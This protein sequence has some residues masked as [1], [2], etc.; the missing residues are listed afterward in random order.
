MQS[1]SASPTR[2][3]QQHVVD[4]PDEQVDACVNGTNVESDSIE[5]PMSQSS[6]QLENGHAVFPSHHSE[7][8]AASDL[9]PSQDALLAAASLHTDQLNEDQRLLDVPESS[10][11]HADHCAPEADP[12]DVSTSKCSD[13]QQSE[14]DERDLEGTSEQA[15]ARTNRCGSD[16]LDND[17]QATTAEGDHDLTATADSALSHTDEVDEDSACRGAKQASAFSLV[18]DYA[19]SPSSQG[20]D[21]APEEEGV[22]QTAAQSDTL[23]VQH[24]EIEQLAT[25]D[26]TSRPCASAAAAHADCSSNELQE[27]QIGTIDADSLSPQPIETP[28]APE[29]NT[30]ELADRPV[31]TDEVIKS[32]TSDTQE[33]PEARPAEAAHPSTSDASD[34]ELFDKEATDRE[35]PMFTE[36]T[37]YVDDSSE[38]DQQDLGQLDETDR[39]EHRSVGESDYEMAPEQLQAE[40]SGMTAAETTEEQDETGQDTVF[41]DRDYGNDEDEASD[42][43]ELGGRSESAM[44]MTRTLSLSESDAM[45]T[46]PNARGMLSESLSRTTALGERAPRFT[47]L[48]KLVKDKVLRPVLQH[49]YAWPFQKPVD[50]VQMHLPVSSFEGNLCICIFYNFFL[51]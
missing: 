49:K 42:A 9:E 10:E 26:D 36:H 16:S 28:T 51:V 45:L 23:H 34:N 29:L 2:G 8:S 17:G 4:L 47:K 44:S 22:T 31:E 25:E 6:D 14:S 19:T 33:L 43:E 11:P 24:V 46:S 18:A 12:M 15:E 1:Q 41:D 35:P 13:E 5:A 7:D 38:I 20:D 37:G 50:P 21:E 40:P 3:D 39:L 27:A 48:L 30:G 32:G